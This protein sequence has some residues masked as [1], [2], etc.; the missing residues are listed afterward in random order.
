[1][2]MQSSWREFRQRAT[3]ENTKNRWRKTQLKVWL[4]IIVVIC[5]F[6]C[7]TSEFHLV[8]HVQ[9]HSW[10]LLRQKLSP[11]VGTVLLFRC[12]HIDA[13]LAEKFVALAAG[14]RL[15]YH[16]IANQT[17]KILVNFLDGWLWIDLN[18]Y[19]GQ[20]LVERLSDLISEK[21]TN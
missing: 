6:T 11:A 5:L 18:F 7:L 16:T 20:A 2:L 12:P 13:F 9:N 3:F 17:L 1:M 8:E 19:F 21:G 10:N 15:K 14:F 4:C